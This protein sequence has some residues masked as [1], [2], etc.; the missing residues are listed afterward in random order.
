MEL[1]KKIR[2]SENEYKV[3]GQVNSGNGESIKTEGNT[4]KT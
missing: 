2:P 3:K 1:K 4:R